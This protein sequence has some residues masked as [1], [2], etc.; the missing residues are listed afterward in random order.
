MT[1]HATASSQVAVLFL[2]GNE[3][4]ECFLNSP[5][6]LAGGF[7]TDSPTIVAKQGETGGGGVVIA[8]ATV[9]FGIPT[10][11]RLLIPRKPQKGK[12]D[13]ALGGV[14]T[15]E[16]LNDLEGRLVALFAKQIGK[17]RR[18]Q[19]IFWRLQ[20]SR[21]QWIGLW[22]CSGEIKAQGCDSA[23]PIEF[24]Q[25]PLRFKPT[26]GNYHVPT[27]IAGFCGGVSG[28]DLFDLRSA[29][30]CC[31]CNLCALLGFLSLDLRDGLGRAKNVGERVRSFLG[32]LYFPRCALL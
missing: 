26:V 10:P 28:F 3:P 7:V 32:L 24:R 23:F 31:V 4:F 6:E 5:L 19:S 11:V 20:F 17:S 2:L 14:R 1:I 22:V 9:L 27:G 21:Q 8:F 30:G 13:G 29:F 15:T 25:F 12:T 18:V 16:L